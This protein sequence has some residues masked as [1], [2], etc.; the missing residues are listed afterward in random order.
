M[1]P[2]QISDLSALRM[3]QVMPSPAETVLKVCFPGS[4]KSLSAPQHFTCLLSLRIPQMWSLPVLM[5]SKATPL[6]ARETWP[7]SSEPQPCRCLLSLRMA[8]VK[9][10]PGATA[11]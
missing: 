3:P 2:R 11:L 6:G 4:S 7:C 5:L 8:Q 9:L 1:E 10:S